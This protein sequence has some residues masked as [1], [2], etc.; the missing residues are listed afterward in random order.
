M[1][2]EEAAAALQSYFRVFP[3]AGRCV[4]FENHSPS[5]ISGNFTAE[6]SKPAPLLYCILVVLKDNV[7]FFGIQTGVNFGEK[8]VINLRSDNLPGKS[9]T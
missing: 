3:T 7:F 1:R 2:E 8:A 9:E 6:L 4:L 5:Q